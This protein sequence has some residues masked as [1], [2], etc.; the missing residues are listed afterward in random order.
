MQ[1]NSLPVLGTFSTMKVYDKEGNSH[2]MADFW[3]EKKAVFVF[4]RHFG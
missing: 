4:V 2:N 1:K 3:A